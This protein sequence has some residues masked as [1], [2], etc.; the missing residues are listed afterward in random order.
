[1]GRA[2]PGAFGIGR[3]EAAP[4]A[5]VPNAN[6]GTVSVIDTATN[7]LTKTITVGGF[8]SWAYVTPDGAKAFIFDPS[9]GNFSSSTPQAIRS[10]PR[11]R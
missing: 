1:L 10:R 8:P 5:Y 6:D 9:S 4:F 11:A 3:A 7:T 2:V